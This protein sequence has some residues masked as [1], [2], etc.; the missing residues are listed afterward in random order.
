VVNHK[1]EVFPIDS[2]VPDDPLMME[3]LEPYQ[4]KLNQMLDLTAV[5]GFAASH[6][7]RFDF[8]GGDSPLGNFVAEA[9]RKHARADIGLMNSLG[10][11][12]DIFTGPITMDDLFNVFPFNNS[13]TTIYLSGNDIQDL[14]DYT[15]RRSAG[16]GCATQ[17]QLSGVEFTMNCNFP[18]DESTCEPDCPPRAENIFM[19]NCGDATLDATEKEQCSKKPLDPYQ[20]YEVA[21]NDYIAHG[22][23][24]FTVLKINNTQVDTGVQLRDAVLEE[25]VRA[26]RCTDQCYS[27]DGDLE[28]RTCDPFKSCL[29]G[30]VEYRSQF[31]EHIYE[32]TNGHGEVGVPQH[33]AV[34]EG[35]CQTLADCYSIEDRCA[36]DSCTSCSQTSDCGDGEE[37]FKGYCLTPDQVCIGGRCRTL[38]EENGDCGPSGG[39]FTCVTQG[40]NV[41]FCAEDRG[42]LCG[43]ARECVDPILI[44]YGDLSTCGG[45]DNCG[46]GEAC[47]DHRCEPVLASCGS[48]SDCDDVTV[49]VGG[50]GEETSCRRGVCTPF[51]GDS[52][53]PCSTDEECSGGRGCVAGHC[54]ELLADCVENRCRAKCEGSADCPVGETCQGDTCLPNA[55]VEESDLETTCLLENVYKA[56]AQCL[57]IPCP[58]A[59][60]DGRIKRLLPPNLD[61]LPEDL[62]PD[63]QEG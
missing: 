3:V 49:L 15:T 6:I 46:E 30:M 31:C 8:N 56:Q 60:S 13:I 33:C 20:I 16:R 25:I 5:Y 37:C 50:I 53:A 39:E 4:L 44:C 61:Q 54:V 11:R 26:D 12:S 21:T 29:N 63:D 43:T 14:L 52:C 62:N 23:S 47:I 48:D 51:A 24:G 36:G 41:R 40:L 55:C 42:G 18:D 27:A 9:I 2:R 45:N 58:D 17:V 1:Y 28:L 34:D 59:A 57:Q 38:C 32:T 7:R 35:G 19:T 22:G 10:I